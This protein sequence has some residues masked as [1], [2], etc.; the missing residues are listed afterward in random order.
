MFNFQSLSVYYIIMN[1]SL[2]VKI[3]VSPDDAKRL[4]DTFK[5]YQF[6]WQTV[7][8][9]SFQ[10]NLSHSQMEAQ[11]AT[12]YKVREVY[13]TLPANLVQAARTD[14]L[15]KIK[16]AKQNKHILKSPP[17]LKKI[18]LRY[19][20]RTSK[21]KGNT[22][23]LACCGG[24]RINVT[25]NEFPHLN[26]LRNR[27]KILSPGIFYQKG[28]FW[29]ILVFQ[30]PEI[31]SAKTH[32]IGIDLGQRNFAATSEGK[33]YKSKILNRNRRKIRF[34]KQKLQKRGTKSARRKFKRLSGK[35][36][37]QS[38]NAIHCLVNKVIQDTKAKTFVIEKLKLPN[39]KGF[40][41]TGKNRR[42]YA[43]PFGLFR[44]ILKYKASIL[45]IQI[46]EVSPY[47]TSQID[48]RGLPDGKR[49]KGLYIGVDGKQLNSDINGAINVVH[50]FDKNPVVPKGYERQADVTQP[51][52]CKS[53]N[54][55]K[56]DLKSC[57]SPVNPAS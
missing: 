29:A 9:W 37:R 22:I 6:A 51:I 55:V 44:Q 18:T 35:E 36:K 48:C 12:Y 32:S 26:E 3:N 23:G 30:I 40:G 8:D 25:F 21:I 15:A 57:N 28:Q 52:A 43:A 24:K 42:K 20:T 38:A 19:D 39:A 49:H 2:K 16:G 4:F 54:Y 46:V 50:K 56:H 11:K 10:N 17:K 47:R 41:K 33:L 14:A 27:Y 45:G 7:S 31:Q 13:P 1:I 53:L 34:L 5:A